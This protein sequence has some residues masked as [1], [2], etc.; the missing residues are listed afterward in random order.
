MYS[1]A[2]AHV[3]L[4]PFCSLQARELRRR[5]RRNPGDEEAQELLSRLLRKDAADAPAGFVADAHGSEA[6][7]PSSSTA[8]PLSGASERQ[9]G[10][11]RLHPDLQRLE[12]QSG[13]GVGVDAGTLTSM[14]SK[15]IQETLQI[16]DQNVSLSL[17]SRVLQ[18]F[19]CGKSIFTRRILVWS[20]NQPRLLQVFRKH[21]TR[22]P[23]LQALWGALCRQ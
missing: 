15:E 8:A 22:L 18:W 23:M 1:L 10:N 9:S 19:W 5:L 21:V 3:E 20:F 11:L 7:V 17:A 12:Q 2:P 6:V 4:P 16:E 14:L 13:S